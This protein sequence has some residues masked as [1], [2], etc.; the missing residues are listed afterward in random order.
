M[1]Q[2]MIGL[3]DSY[4]NQPLSVAIEALRD[5][6]YWVR[7]AAILALTEH[8][9]RSKARE[10]LQQLAQDEEPRIR[11]SAL[12]TQWAMNVAQRMEP[13]LAA[14]RANLSVGNLRRASKI[15][16]RIYREGDLKYLSVLKMG[17]LANQGIGNPYGFLGMPQAEGFYAFG[18]AFSPKLNAFELLRYEIDLKLDPTSLLIGPVGSRLLQDSVLRKT[19]REDPKFEPLHKFYQFRVLTGI[20][21][22]RVVED[23][24]LPEIGGSK[25]PGG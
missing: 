24:K 9:D 21:L 16:E 5:P 12:R 17:L 15:T 4:L 19:I 7:L 14:A 25:P 8:Q 22:P 6:C 1:V 3:R 13:I 18:E 2:A 23:I 20:E 11:I 10:P